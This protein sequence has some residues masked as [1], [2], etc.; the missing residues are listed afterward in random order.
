MTSQQIRKAFIEFFKSKEHQIVDSAP[1]V[2]KN[3]PT[4]MFTNAGMNQFKDIFLGNDPVKY[5]RIA[6]TQK[7]LRVSGKHNDLEEVGHDTYH[8]TMFE[9]LG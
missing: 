8:H 5:K 7:C 2:V 4:L 1:M 9:M 6:D 3:D